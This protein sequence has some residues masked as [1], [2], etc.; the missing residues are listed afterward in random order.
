MTSDR[1]PFVPRPAPPETVPTPPLDASAAPMVCELDPGHRAVTFWWRGQAEEVRVRANKLTD[2]SDADL[3]ER[4]GD[5]WHRTYRVRAGWRCSYHLVVDGQEII[6]PLNPRAWQGY[7]IAD[8][9]PPSPWLAGTTAP[10]FSPTATT[11]P[12]FSPSGTTTPPAWSA[13]STP[14]SSSPAGATSQAPSLAAGEPRHRLTRLPTGWR[15]DPV[16]PAAGTLVL[17]DGQDWADD[18]PVMLDNLIAAAEIPPVTAWL[19]E[20]AED[21]VRRLTCDPAFVD[22]LPYGGHTV[23]AGQSLGGLTAVYAAHRHPGRFAAAISQSGSF[24]WPNDPAREWLTGQVRDAPP[25]RV[26]LQAGS[27]EWALSGPTERMRAALGDAATYEEFE[28]G[29]DRYCW[30]NELPAALI[31]VYGGAPS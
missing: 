19:V 26:H 23:I 8:T 28:G 11:T 17:L 3:L 13:G 2:R 6:D 12:P 7:S 18:L 27:L 31:A 9:T 1:P 22:G 16:R 25:P 14:R 20:T 5:L 24:W 15:Y 29:H 10:P 4:T 30:L 21:R